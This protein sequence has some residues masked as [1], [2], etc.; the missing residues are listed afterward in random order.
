MKHITNITCT[1]KMAAEIPTSGKLLLLSQIID[2]VA[3]AL[4]QKESEDGGL[5]PPTIPDDTT[6]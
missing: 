3:A 2:V 6:E 4:T 5:I 1:P